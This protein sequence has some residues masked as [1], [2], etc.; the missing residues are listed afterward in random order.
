MDYIEKTVVV[1]EYFQFGVDE[2]PDWFINTLLSETPYYCII[3]SEHSSDG[4]FITA[5]RG[6]IIIKGIDG[7]IYSCK[8]HIFKKTDYKL[9]EEKESKQQP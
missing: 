4:F 9:Y 6:D 5:E 7:K 1:V 3:S 2:K 8:E